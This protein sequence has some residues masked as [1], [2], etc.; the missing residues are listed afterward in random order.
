MSHLHSNVFYYFRGPRS[1]VLDE[2]LENNTTK[3]LANVLQHSGTRVRRAFLQWLGVDADGSQ[4]VIEIQR[5]R[6]RGWLIQR[7]S[8]RRLL[9]ITGKGTDTTQPLQT[10]LTSPDASGIPD[11]WLCGKGFVVLVESKLGTNVDRQQIAR[12]LATLGED[13]ESVVWRTWDDIHDLLTRLDPDPDPVPSCTDQF[14]VRQLARYLEM[15]G[16]A[17]F[18]RFLREH[19]E[20]FLNRD[21]PEVSEWVRS[22]LNDL[23]HQVCQNLGQP[24]FDVHVGALRRE[25]EYAWVGIGPKG[26]ISARPHLT[27]GMNSGG[28][29]VCLT[30]DAGP[31]RTKLRRILAQRSNDLREEIAKLEEYEVRV[32]EKVKKQ[33]RLF[34]YHQVLSISCSHLTT[35]SDPH[36]QRFD[37]LAQEVQSLRL[38][39]FYVVRWFTLAETLKMGDETVAK[40]SDVARRLAPVIQLIDAA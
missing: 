31:A 11:A 34:E 35:E 4:L 38:P 29:E 27:I 16:Q 24:N 28:I 14:L 25:S 17:K 30:V 6:P 1:Q 19:F 8:T 32:M 21:D 5:A 2:Q 36:A 20:F 10:T 22:S 23:G 12:Y 37:W 40:V 33:A 15:I 39:T 26:G 9:L 13:I 18:V 7:A 3:A